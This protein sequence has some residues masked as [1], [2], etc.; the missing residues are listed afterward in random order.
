MKRSA[1]IDELTL[2]KVKRFPPEY[3]QEVKDFIDFIEEKKINPL[4]VKGK[5]GFGS[6]KGF[7]IYMDEDFD[8]PLEDF[9]D[10]M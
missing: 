8:A 4:P 2:E 6:G 5:R 1:M 7:L 10:Y 3:Q 9:K